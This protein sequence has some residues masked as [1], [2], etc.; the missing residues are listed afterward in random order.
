MKL[1]GYANFG[2]IASIGHVSGSIPV[3]LEPGAI[4]SGSDYYTVYI[5]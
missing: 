1:L 2:A 3:H 5:K 4:F